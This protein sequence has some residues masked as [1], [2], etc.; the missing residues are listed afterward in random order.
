[1]QCVWL[2]RKIF[3]RRKQMLKH[4]M[5]R[6]TEHLTNVHEVTFVVPAVYDPP[7]HCKCMFKFCLHIY[8]PVCFTPEITKKP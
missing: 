8:R 4:V 3:S 6:N 1:M 7:E 2:S 5:F